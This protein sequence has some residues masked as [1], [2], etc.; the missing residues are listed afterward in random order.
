MTRPS[1]VVGALLTVACLAVACSAD[2]PPLVDAPATTTT[3][4]GTTTVDESA[5]DEPQ[6]TWQTGSSD[7]LFDQDELHTF[8]LTIPEDDLAFLDADPTAEVYVEGELQFGGETVSEVGIRYK[9]SHGAWVGCVDGADRSG[10]KTCTKLSMKVKINWG[11][12]HAERLFYD[13][14]KLQFHAVNNDS[15]LMNDR[16]GYW[17]FR[18]AGVVAPRAVHARL[19]VNGEFL[20]VFVLVEQIDGRFTREHF[21]DGTGNLYKEVWPIETDGEPADVETVLAALRTNE[22]EADISRFMAFSNE[23][24][25][26][27]TA[28]E[29]RAVIER[30]V[31]VDELVQLLAVD[32]FIRHDDGALHFYCDGPDGECIN[33]NYYW[34]DNPTTGLFHLIPWDLDNAFQNIIA[35]ANRSTPIPDA[36]GGITADCTNFD[37]LGNGVYQRSNGCDPI[38]ATMAQYD[39]G[40]A[41]TT[42]LISSEVLTAG[43]AQAIITGWQDQ[44]RDSVALADRDHDDAL[45]F[46][47]WQASVDDLLVRLAHARDNS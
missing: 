8:F 43:R 10:A 31:A 39:D 3:T 12:E 45:S 41:T 6:P 27:V 33:K 24:A 19:V 9:G 37:N 2:P 20:G 5:D 4:E 38:F 40:F 42:E 23:L 30:W 21:E 44:I 1:R 17:T 25:G 29:Q 35:P 26:A 47:W 16:L 32:R 28:D 15:T 46:G 11:E 18:E 22:E 34:Y 13:V 7:V 14:R 36:L